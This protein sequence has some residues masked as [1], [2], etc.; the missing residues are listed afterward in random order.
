MKDIPPR[1]LEYSQTIMYRLSILE[2]LH[3][4]DEAVSILDRAERE[5]R[6]VDLTTSLEFKARI[7][8]ELKLREE[9]ENPGR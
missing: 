8:S 9:A 1:H 2:E 6:M 5:E 7:K 3:R 4:Y